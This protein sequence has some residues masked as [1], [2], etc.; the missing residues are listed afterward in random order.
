M[1]AQAVRPRGGGT[2]GRAKPT[3]VTLQVSISSGMN[4]LKTHLFSDR[5]ATTTGKLSLLDPGMLDEEPSTRSRCAT[6]G[7]GRTTG[8]ASL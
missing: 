4:R 8:P 2:L 5:I 6:P 7:L 1:V 3:G